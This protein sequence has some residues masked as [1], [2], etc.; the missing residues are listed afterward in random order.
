MSFLLTTRYELFEDIMTSSGAA[1]ISDERARHRPLTQAP[2]SERDKYAPLVL[3]EGGGD[4]RGHY[5]LMLTDQFMVE[6]AQMAAFEAG[7]RE[8]CGYSWADVALHGIRTKM[9]K[10][11]ERVG[12]D[13]EAGMFV[14]YGEDLVALQQLGAML[15]DVFH[16]P[17]TL[18]SWVKAAPFEYD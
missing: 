14:A 8:G 3:F 6:S 11:E 16:D 10:V 7:G 15:R 4:R 2:Y 5:T 1:Y 13:P 18:Q 12:M 9:P 17:K